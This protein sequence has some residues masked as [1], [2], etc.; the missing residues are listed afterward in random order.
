MKGIEGVRSLNFL[1]KGIKTEV[2][3]YK[4]FPSECKEERSESKA[5]YLIHPVLERKGRVLE[6]AKSNLFRRGIAYLGQFY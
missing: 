6:V 2:G 1:L 4:R 3:L 5:G